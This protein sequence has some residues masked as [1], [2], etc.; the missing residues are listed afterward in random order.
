MGKEIGYS[1]KGKKLQLWLIRRESSAKEEMDKRKAF[2]HIWMIFKVWFGD[3]I[4][5]MLR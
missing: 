2:E 4:I 3:M 5:R 1:V